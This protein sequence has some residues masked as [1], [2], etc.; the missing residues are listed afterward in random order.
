MKI[1][2]VDKMHPS[3]LDMFNDLGID[4]D[5]FP[6]ISREDLISRIASYEGLVIRSKTTVDRE[7]IKAGQQLK[8]VA[9]AGSGTDNLDIDYLKE[10][11]IRVFNAGEGNRDAVGDHTIGLI[12]ALLRNIVKSNNEIVQ[13]KWLRE[14]NR[15]RE[16]NTMTVGIIGYGH[17]GQAVVKRLHSFGCK[18]LVHDK[19]KFGFG[20]NFIEESTLEKIKEKANILSLHIPLTFETRR[21]VDDNF[22]ASFQHNLYLVNTSRGEIVDTEALVRGLN[23]GKIIGAALD[24]LEP[25]GKSFIKR[26]DENHLQS[27][28]NMENVIVTPHV[29]GWTVESYQRINEVLIEKIKKEFIHSTP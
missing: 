26:R 17:T 22:F 19:Y 11:G 4:A 7:L 14:E 18:V 2:I 10:K 8:F 3:I 20:N 12:L 13:D 16:L 5:Y 23:N 29:A 9:R 24:V 27:L 6:E 1:L 25:E 21:I 15:G 28:L